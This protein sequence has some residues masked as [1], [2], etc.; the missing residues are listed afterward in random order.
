M[1]SRETYNDEPQS[2]IG[3]RAP[4]VSAWT[5]LNYFWALIKNEDIMPYIYDIWALRQA[6]ERDYVDNEPNDAHQPSS[7]VQKYDAYVPA[8][9]AWIF[10]EGKKLY[11]T[12]MDLTPSD[13]NQGDPGRGGDLWKGKAEYSKERWAFWKQRFEEISEKTDLREE[14]R[15]IAREA[16]VTMSEAEK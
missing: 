12:E 6:L 10:G 15:K 8:A 16:A 1:C 4:E 5:N 7:A 13:R 9:A 2:G 14:T 3:F 11:L